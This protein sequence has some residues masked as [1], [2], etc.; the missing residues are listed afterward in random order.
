MGY[1]MVD[2][3][4]YMGGWGGMVFG[5]LMML[6]WFAL[7][8]GLIVLIVRWLGGTP[9]R[10][11]SRDALDSLR[12]RFARGEIDTAEFEERSQQLRASE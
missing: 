11:A 7:L 5:G 3:W 10:T 9:R 8:I 4:G 1:G 6:F 12:Q 2:G